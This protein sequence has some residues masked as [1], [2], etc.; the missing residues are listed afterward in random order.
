MN[1][2]S[3]I[4]ECEA[5][6]DELLCAAVGDALETESAGEL[7]A[8]LSNCSGCRETLEESRELVDSLRAALSPTELPAGLQARI[9]Q[10]W[11]G[12]TLRRAGRVRRLLPLA[13]L[14]AAASLLVAVLTPSE[15]PMTLSQADAAEIASAF[16][17][18]QWNDPLERSFDTVGEQLDSIQRELD[19]DADPAGALPWTA[20][21]DWDSPAR[22]E[23]SS[24]KRGLRSRSVLVASKSGVGLDLGRAGV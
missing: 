6:R 3:P 17:L 11:E 5:L 21:D 24:S 19:G 4:A 2:E 23:D 8:H 1:A 13:A 14:A 16:G 12:Q 9:H 18:L 15:Q 22:D 20:D 10:G 7:E